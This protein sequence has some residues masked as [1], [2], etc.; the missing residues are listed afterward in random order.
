MTHLYTWIAAAAALLSVG[1]L[2]CGCRGRDNFELNPTAKD[3][4]IDYGTN[5]PRR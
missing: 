2:L 4:P 3:A 1:S 5:A